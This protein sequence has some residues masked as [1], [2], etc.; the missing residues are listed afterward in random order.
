MDRYLKTTFLVRHPLHK[1]QFAY[2]SGRS[3]ETALHCF[4]GPVQD[5]LDRKEYALACFLDIQGAFDNAQF[6][7][8]EQALRVRGVDSVLV[9]WAMNSLRQRVVS[10]SVGSASCTALTTQGTA[11]GGVLSALWFVLVVDT[12]LCQLNGRRFLTVGYSDDTTILLRGICVR[13]LCAQMQKALDIVERWCAGAGLSVSPEKSELMLFTNR[14]RPTKPSPIFLGGKPLRYADS[15]KYLG[16]HITPKLNWAVHAQKKAAAAQKALWQLRGA[17]RCTWGLQPRVAKWLYEAVVRPMVAYACLF[18]HTAL[19]RA[20]VL[21]KL[22]TVQ[23]LGCL[24]ATSAFRSSPLVPL[25]VLC[26]ILP[27]DLYLQYRA[28]CTAYRLQTLGFGLKNGWS[29]TGYRAIWTKVQRLQVP[30][31]ADLTAA[32]FTPELAC[33]WDGEGYNPSQPPTGLCCFT[34]GFDGGQEGTCVALYCSLLREAVFRVRAHCSAYQAEQVALS[35]LCDWLGTLPPRKVT[36]IVSSSSLWLGLQRYKVAE[37]QLLSTIVLLKEVCE[38]HEVTISFV[39]QKGGGICRAV[40]RRC[41]NLTDADTVQDC[42][43]AP[44]IQWVYKRFLA[45]S[46]RIQQHRW[47]VDAKHRQSHLFLGRNLPTPVQ[48]DWLFG[49]GRPQLYTVVG[50]LTGHNSLNRHLSVM[51]IAQSGLCECGADLE[52]SEHFLCYCQRY[53]R[54]RAEIYGQQHLKPEEATADWAAMLTYA[55]HSER[56]PHLEDTN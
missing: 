50:L 22:Q 30:E 14:Y 18:W 47:R 43:I 42:L 19:T 52:S 51:G 45:E 33:Q 40:K 17:A 10:T 38:L 54:L 36:I 41:Q 11:Q 12:L 48:R 55:R 23:R 16:L 24:M 7:D 1:N 25:E 3:C 53:A 20:Y 29:R 21:R 13:T 32:C 8:I 31:C 28:L 5:S 39:G 27:I 56:F 49:L 46:W 26:G 15:V 35:E 44:P 6:K 4:L 34:S 37:E 2:Q 9:D